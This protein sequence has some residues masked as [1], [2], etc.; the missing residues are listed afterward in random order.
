MAT[1]SS[2]LQTSPFPVLTCFIGATLKQ[3]RDQTNVK[4]DIPNKSGN[5]SLTVPANGNATSRSPSPGDVASGEE[6]DEP[7]VPISV[8]G[9]APLVNE[10]IGMIQDIINVRTSK[11]TQRIK[12]VPPHILPFLVKESEK[13]TE[14]IRGEYLDA[15]LDVT[16]NEKQGQIVL[17]GDRVAV[18]P[19]IEALKE[20]QEE[21]QDT[22]KNV[23]TTIPRNQHRFVLNPT[24]AEEFLNTYNVV[25]Q[26]PEAGEAITI[27]GPKKLGDALTALL[28]VRVSCP[29]ARLISTDR[30]ALAEIYH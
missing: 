22:V 3:I 25:I 13:I 14:R 23:T 19:T 7:T 20:A 21:L 11:T 18:M 2:L 5:A 10:A 9:P 29:I 6:E 1:N 30:L 27:W 16:V 24:V 26:P 8:T 12:D 4:I 15:W 17:N 28:D